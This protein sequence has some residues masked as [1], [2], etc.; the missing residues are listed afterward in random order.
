MEQHNKKSFLKVSLGVLLGIF[1]LFLTIRAFS[2]NYT[3]ISGNIQYNGIKP[4]D[5]SKGKVVLLQKELGDTDFAVA[6]DE[7]AL[8]DEAF[9]FWDKAE[10]GSTYQLKAY[11]EIE[12]K[13]I[14][15]SS[16]I[17][18]TAPSVDQVLV[19]NISAEDLPLTV[20]E[21]TPT[22]ISGELDLN[23][24]IPPGS[25][26]SVYGK[27]GNGEYILASSGIDAVDGE[28]LSWD[29]AKAGTRYTFYAVLI[30]PAGEEIGT[31]E[32]LQVVA[33]AAGQ[34]LRIDS[35]VESPDE[36]VSIS[37]TLRLNGP[38]EPNSTVLL[39]QRTPGETNYHAFDRIAAV[40]NAKW[41]FD[42]AKNGASYE[43]TASLQVNESNTTSGTVLRV[44]APAKDEVIT[45]DTKFSLA[46]PTQSPTATCNNASEGKWNAVIRFPTVE[47]ATQYWIE[48]GTQ[49]G[50]RD[51]FG[52]RVDASSNAIE[53][54]VL[55]SE[56]VSTYARY[57]YAFNSAC[58]E[59]QCFSS[60]SPTLVFK[61]PQ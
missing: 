45:I 24:Y 2:P 27:E 39:L 3:S 19:F 16:M 20:L 34:K 60:Y 33:P 30:S 57:A 49:Q 52:Q 26:V 7:I 12:G 50:Q 28:P 44:T 53:R 41:S 54:N 1:L 42:E 35:I 6:N 4:E 43:I 21:G 25:T 56:G 40:N 38:T 47:N 9:W 17:T 58:R 48:A 11:I 31:S 51:L 61:C 32:E 55:V 23:G 36:I 5:P 13:R 10:E 15:D 8:E 59:E 14:A 29:A 22:T 46:P 18:V 37:G